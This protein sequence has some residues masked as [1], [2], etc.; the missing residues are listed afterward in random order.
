MINLIYKEVSS[1]FNSLSGYIVIS[2]FLVCTGLFLWVI[3]GQINIIDIGYADLFSFFIIA[4]QLYLFL[5]PAICMKLFSEERKNG[6]LEL[7]LT[8]PIS[9]YT[10]VISKYLAAFILVIISLIPT[11]IY[12]YSI[13]SL[14]SPV[15]SIDMGLV[16]G[17]YIALMFLATIYIAVSIFAGAFTN[18]QLTSF[19]YSITLC[20]IMYS[21]FDYI[22]TIPILAQ[23]ENEI[24]FMGINS[25]YSPMAR[26]VIDT[27]DI[28]YFISVS[29]LFIYLTN[30][31]I[32]KKR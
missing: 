4:P 1:F 19:I 32:A 5:I 28:M 2:I 30:K 21:G 24:S 31:K 22:A 27:R 7:L 13:Y 26:G 14:A 23:L 6:T 12:V 29:T 20:F 10:I 17:S 11:L 15:G 25:H 9:T 8:R 16:W 3:P 18:S